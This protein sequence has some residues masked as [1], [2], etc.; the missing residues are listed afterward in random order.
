[1]A[2]FFI[3]YLRVSKRLR[4]D[5]LWASVLLGDGS[6][7]THVLLQTISVNGRRGSL[8]WEA[9][10]IDSLPSVSTPANEWITAQTHAGAR[11]G[12]C[13]TPRPGPA[14]QAWCD[15]LIAAMTHRPKYLWKTKHRNESWFAL[16]AWYLAGTI[17]R[18]IRLGLSLCVKSWFL[19]L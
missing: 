5:L 15:T 18:Q 9:H 1:M 19:T 8:R 11:G 6:L 17:C 4:R 13:R 3:P 7:W 16:S 2:F 10:S 14:R 12:T